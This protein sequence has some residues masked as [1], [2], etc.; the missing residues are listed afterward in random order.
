MNSPQS[1]SKPLTNPYLNR[2]GNNP[3][4]IRWST[5]RSAEKVNQNNVVN[6]PITPQQFL[7]QTKK[8]LQVKHRNPTQPQT[9]SKLNQYQERLRHLQTKQKQDIQSRPKSPQQTQSNLTQNPNQTGN[10]YPIPN[11]N[12]PLTNP[13]LQAVQN[14]EKEMLEEYKR[15]TN[16]EAYHSQNLILGLISLA[17]YFLGAILIT[18]FTSVDGQPTVTLE[19]AEISWQLLFN[20]FSTFIVNLLR[21][22]FGYFIQYG[23]LFGFFPEY[24]TLNVEPVPRYLMPLD[25]LLKGATII[26]FHFFWMNWDAQKS[27]DKGFI[28]SK[29][30]Y[31][32]SA[33]KPLVKTNKKPSEKF[34]FDSSPENINTKKFQQELLEGDSENAELIATMSDQG[35]EEDEDSMIED[36][37]SLPFSGVHKP[38]EEF[39]HN[40][41]AKIYG[42]IRKRVLPGSNLIMSLYFSARF[43]ITLDNPIYL[44]LYVLGIMSMF[45]CMQSFLLI[46]DHNQYPPEEE[47]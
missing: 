4:N 6:P 18:F 30:P 9:N 17:S 24:G 21:N 15:E 12:Y 36:D 47:V 29:Y 27:L 13:H 7:Q 23:K 5:S 25:L 8:Q 35:D 43:V 19:T 44:V 16:N 34:D 28:N 14:A 45:W 31:L 38:I 11:S 1:Y 39:Y 10:N 22:A 32:N 37:S 3:A 40:N 20:D 46:L 33:K 26:Y 2:A 42:V 41:E